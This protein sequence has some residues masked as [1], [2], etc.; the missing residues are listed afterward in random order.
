MTS[1]RA[2]PAGS[3]SALLYAIL[4]L[5][6]PPV[7][8]EIEYQFLRVPE[9]VVEFFRLPFHLARKWRDLAQDPHD[10]IAGR[11]LPESRT[12]L[13]PRDDYHFHA[14]FVAVSGD[15]ML[16]PGSSATQVPNRTTGRYPECRIRACGNSLL[17]PIAA[18][19]FSK[20]VSRAVYETA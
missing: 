9:Q 14:R 18:A 20:Q 4:T 5:V 12:R 13:H 17:L 1:F 11:H 8:G 7:P 15:V 19:Q 3:F 16:L 2:V 10:V 6:R